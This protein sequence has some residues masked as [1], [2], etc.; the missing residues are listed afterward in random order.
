MKDPV[1]FL[2]PAALA[3][4][5]ALA[6]SFLSAVADRFG[7][8]GPPGAPN[9]AW[10]N[11]E[12]FLQYTRVLLPF[13]PAPLIPMAGWTATV[14]EVVL[15]LGLLAGFQLRWFALGSAGLLLSFGLSMTLA[16]GPEPAF[17]CS[18]WTAATAALVLAC[19][20]QTMR[21]TS[22]TQNSSYGSGKSG[23]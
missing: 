2:R 1:R 4:R 16:L 11:F 7:L 13:V 14:S 3:L 17:S 22:P 9:V 21:Q 19:L 5:A 8:W 18:V 10:G 6:L 12:A 15:A 23:E 20:D